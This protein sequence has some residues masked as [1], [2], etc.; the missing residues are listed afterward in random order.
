ME[1]RNALI[2][3]AWL[4]CVKQDIRRPVRN[5]PYS[6]TQTAECGGTGQ[7][8]SLGVLLMATNSYEEN[9]IPEGVT[10]KA[11]PSIMATQKNQSVFLDSAST[12]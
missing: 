12:A 8:G 4:G 3:I 2:S 1:Q 5:H 10:P 6:L 11:R 9:W 7:Y